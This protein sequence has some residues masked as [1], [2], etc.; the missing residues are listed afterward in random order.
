M[1]QAAS[2]PAFVPKLLATHHIEASQWGR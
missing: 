2:G 1:K